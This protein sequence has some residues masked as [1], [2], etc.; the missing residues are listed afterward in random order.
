MQR[1]FSQRSGCSGAQ[2]SQ[3]TF[4]WEERKQRKR[5]ERRMERFFRWR[6]E[7]RESRTK[8]VT[9]LASHKFMRMLVELKGTELDTLINGADRQSRV[10]E[11]LSNSKECVHPD[12]DSNHPWFMEWS[13]AQFTG[14]YVHTMRSSPKLPSVRHD[15]TMF[16]E[17]VRW[18]SKLQ[19]GDGGAPTVKIKRPPQPCNLLVEPEVQGGCRHLRERLLRAADGG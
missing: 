3:G 18:R 13:A 14:K 16:I 6:Q 12:Y 17:K 19:N 15:L 11:Y 8:L 5:Q 2:G 10:L 9:E 1:G 4:I 7:W